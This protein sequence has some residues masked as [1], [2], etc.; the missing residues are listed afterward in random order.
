MGARARSS[1]QYFYCDHVRR[2]DLSAHRHLASSVSPAGPMSGIEFLNDVSDR[3]ADPPPPSRDRRWWLLGGVALAVVVMIWAL[4]RPVDHAPSMSQDLPA[5][6]PIATSAPVA[7][8]ELICRE[9][10]NCRRTTVVPLLLRQVINRY[11]PGMDSVRVHSY[12]TRSLFDDATY[13]V[14]RRVDV[15]AGP[16]AV[17]ILVR[18]GIPEALSPLVSVPAGAR[19]VLVRGDPFGYVVALQYV[20]PPSGLPS[21]ARLRALATEPG[22]ESL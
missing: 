15:V 13:L 9:E 19:S 16:A 21:L 1:R 2:L 22:L 6:H 17:A 4:T 10:P 3:P 11:V 7:A 14:A 5:D 8:G 18:R 12:L 20:G